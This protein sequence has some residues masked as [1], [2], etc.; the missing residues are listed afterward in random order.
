[1]VEE[2]R[3]NPFLV[4]GTHLQPGQMLNVD[5]STKAKHRHIYKLETAV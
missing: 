4:K 2:I 5:L 3:A 1:M